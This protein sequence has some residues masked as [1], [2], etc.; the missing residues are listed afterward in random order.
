MNRYRRP[1]SD[2]GTRPS[3]RPPF[4]IA[5]LLLVAGLLAGL[6]LA[7]RLPAPTAAG[8]PYGLVQTYPNPSPTP[9]DEFGSAVAWMPPGDKLAVAARSDELSGTTRV[10]AIYILD[11]NSG[12]VVSVLSRGGST[13]NDY[14]GY[15]LAVS[16]TEILAGAPHDNTGD[17]DSGAAYLFDSLTGSLLMTFTNPFPSA[18][19]YFGWSVAVISDTAALVGEPQ[20]STSTINVGRAY[21]CQIESGDCSFAIDNPDSSGDG[22]Q[23]GY[24]V[25]ALGDKFAIAA[26]F[27]GQHG[28]VYVYTTTTGSLYHTITLTTTTSGDSFGSALAIVNGNLLI[29]ASNGGTSILNTAGAAYIYTPGGTLLRSFYNPDPNDGSARFGAS[30]AS[31]G[32][33]I[34]IGAPGAASGEGRA[35]LYSA[36]TGAL[37]DTFQAASPSTSDNFG[38]S[39][40]VLGENFLVGAPGD[41]P[42]ALGGNAYRFGVAPANF[43]KSAKTVNATWARPGDLITYTLTLSNTGNVAAPFILTDTL[44]AHLA[45]VSAPGMS[46]SSTLTATGTLSGTT[47]LSFTVAVRASL[48]FRGTVSN[49]AQL[50]GDGTLRN[51]PAPLVNVADRL[52]LPLLRR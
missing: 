7:A 32:T 15:S 52:W 50:S 2:A 42:A 26:P 4:R 36:S 44:G 23:F 10:G 47:A 37:I 1:E 9:A 34:L 46:G 14:L 51:L 11:K 28:K 33:F 29:G 17:S 22:A 20:F 24:S 38:S 49:T 40:A 16:G 27:D 31:D 41:N 48:G 25:A 18:F 5:L 45:L 35:Y 12:S 3:S 6:A 8:S 13:A 19:D 43:S 39:V 30:V 21:I